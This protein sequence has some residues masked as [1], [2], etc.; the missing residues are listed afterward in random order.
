MYIEQDT[1]EIMKSTFLESTYTF[2]GY[3][4]YLFEPQLSLISSQCAVKEQNTPKP[5]MSHTQRKL[6]CFL[7]F[8]QEGEQI[9]HSD[10]ILQFVCQEQVVNFKQ[11]IFLGNLL[12]NKT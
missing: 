5:H 7:R 3:K 12:P 1:S 2:E 11:L 9:E 10:D 8:E 4:K 6:L